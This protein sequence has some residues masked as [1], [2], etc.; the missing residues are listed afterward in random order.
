MDRL[1]FL[2]VFTEHFEDGG[3]CFLAIGNFCI[4][5]G[6]ECLQ[7]FG[8]GSIQGEHGGSAVG[9]GAYGTK[10]ETVAGEGKRRGTVTVGIVD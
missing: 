9:L 1:A 6:F 3:E 7:L 5:L 10:F 2:D 8:Y 4:D